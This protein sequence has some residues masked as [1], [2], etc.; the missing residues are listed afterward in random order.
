MALGSLRS[1]GPTS[2]PRRCFL[3]NGQRPRFSLSQPATVGG[4]F[5]GEGAEGR[6]Q[7][8]QSRALAL[9]ADP[10]DLGGSSCHRYGSP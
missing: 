8:D 6:T 2:G 10:P 7:V 9:R 4:L 3:H 5:A 1:Y